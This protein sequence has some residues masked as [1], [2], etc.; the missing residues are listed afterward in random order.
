MKKILIDKYGRQLDYLRLSVTDRCNFR[1]YYCMPEEGVNFTDRKEL[2]TYEEL[3]ELTRLFVRLGVNKIRI[4]GGEPFIRK[5]IL[6]FL[7]RISE[8]NNLKQITITS[9]GTLSHEQKKRL[10]S[11]G[12]LKINISMDSLDRKRFFE[13]TRRDRFDEV[14]QCVLD[15]LADGFEVKLNCVVADDKNIADILP[16]IGLTKLHPI[17]VRFL[18]E[19]PFNGKG[20]FVLP[21]WNHRA[22]LDHIERHFPFI[23]KLED[24]A[25][26]TSVNY[27][28]PGYQG[29][30][31][32][33]P[34][35]SRT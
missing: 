24:E 23:Q 3:E 6:S 20:S 11:L 32:V 16:F 10:K 21:T 12:I 4:T 28:I 7:E 8:I 25:H 27:K 26:S 17:S 1:C 22:I 9:N 19:M 35:F 14:F 31:G 15:L 30:F 18:E 29:S 5:G 13:M 2:L 33:I 34:S